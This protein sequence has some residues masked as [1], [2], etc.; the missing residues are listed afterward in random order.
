MHLMML[1]VLRAQPFQNLD[2]IF[3]IGRIHNNRL[4]AA[5]ERGILL[6][7]LAVFVNRRRTNALEF[8]TGKRRLENIGSVKATFRTSS[9]NNRMEFIDKENHRI[10]D[11]LEFH[12]KA[13][14]AF[15]ELSTILS[16]GHHGGH[17]KRHHALV[18]QE[19]R[20]FLLD[21][22]LRE[23]FDNRR[24]TDTRFTDEG[25]IIFLA[26]AKNLNQAFDFTA[27]TNNRIK[28]TLLGKRRQ[29]AT[30]MI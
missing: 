28:L 18:H 10:I 16:T 24:L 12:D 20:N 15:F 26:T 8:T 7:I 5:F 21:N 23:T 2:G 9:P 19:F 11:A 17:V 1:F 13:L 30:E 6:D 29:V 27:T 25:R 22:L 4:E 14:H 3:G